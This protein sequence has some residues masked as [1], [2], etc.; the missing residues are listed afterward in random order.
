MGGNR[1]AL[2]V[3]CCYDVEEWISQAK[4]CTLRWN[5]RW[6]FVCIGALAVVQY[7]EGSH[8]P[9]YGK[10]LYV[11]TSSGKGILKTANDSKFKPVIFSF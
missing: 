11:I 6:F 3:M 8:K 1:I 2:P 4:Y 7:D 9:G 10:G 5:F